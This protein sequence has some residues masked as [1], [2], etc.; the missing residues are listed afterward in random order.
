MNYIDNG[1]PERREE[2]TREP[3]PGVLKYW[4]TISAE[5]F[6]DSTK[7]EVIAFVQATTT[8]M[9][10]WQ[11]AISGDAVAAIGMVKHCKPPSKI[12]GRR[13]CSPRSF[14]RCR[15]RRACVRNS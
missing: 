3:W 9:P 13:S 12:P 2:A 1:G 4:R 14:A 8:T 5:A 15:L 10:E 7:A 6:D 11:R